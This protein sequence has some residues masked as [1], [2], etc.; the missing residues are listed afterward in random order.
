MCNPPP[1]VGKVR[2]CGVTPLFDVRLEDVLDRKH[3]PPLGLKD[4]EEWLLFVE[5]SPENLYFTLWLREYKLRYNQWA[6]QT[7]FHREASSEFRTNWSSHNSSQL[8]MFYARAKQTFLTPNSDYELNL[9]SS[10]L[11]P[12]HTSMESPHP[13]PAIFTDVDAEVYQLLDDSLRRFVHAQF[14]NVG[15]H[16]VLCGIVAGFLFCLIGSIPSITLNLVREQSRWMRLTAFPGLFIGLTIALSALNGICLGVYMF[17]DLRQLR[18]FELSRPP[19]SKPQPLPAF[20]RRSLSSQR[21]PQQINPVLPVQHPRKSSQPHCRPN[22][23]SR[24]ASSSSL[25]SQSSPS[26]SGSVYI[27]ADLVIHISPEYY[28]TDPVDGPATTPPGPDAPNYT[29]PEKSVHYDE[30][31]SPTDSD[32]T[33]TATFIHQYDYDDDNDDPDLEMGLERLPERHQPIS[34]FDFDALPPRTP[35]GDPTRLSTQ[36]ERDCCT[37]TPTIPPPEASPSLMAR[38]QSRCDIKRWRLQTGFLEPDQTSSFASSDTANPYNSHIHTSKH[39]LRLPQPHSSS[40][41]QKILP[42]KEERVRKRF[43]LI[44]AVPAFAVPLTRVLSPVIVRGQWEIVVRSA[45]IAFLISW[46]LVGIFL[47]I[48]IPASS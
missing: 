24:P 48:P 43:R 11:A 7:R 35:N 2:S 33:A 41:E 17:G 1:A 16:R 44:Q 29:F 6:A 14:N 46:V 23:L 19:I 36:Y 27:N 47:A 28:D 30:N 18:K 31:A 34:P 5:M 9:P 32:F 22:N 42:P 4:F 15:N 39:K 21:S 13:D 37:P 8:A 38:I 12:F 10:I 3:L 20:K 45:A 40:S 26:S 25:G